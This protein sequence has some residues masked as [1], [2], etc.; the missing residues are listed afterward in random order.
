MA[1]KQEN[2][3]SSEL[4]KFPHNTVKAKSRVASVRK[5][6]QSV[7]QIANITSLQ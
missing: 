4:P 6:T 7:Q 1:T 2:H 3:L 5:T